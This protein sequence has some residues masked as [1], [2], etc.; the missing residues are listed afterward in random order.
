[1]VFTSHVSFLSMLMAQ[2]GLK[3]D[4]DYNNISR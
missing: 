2:Q 4:R 3:C 1:M